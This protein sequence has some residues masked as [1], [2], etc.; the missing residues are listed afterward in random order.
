M[1]EGHADQTGWALVQKGG[2]SAVVEGARMDVRV[3]TADVALQADDLLASVAAT[4]MSHISVVRKS[5]FNRLVEGA[6]VTFDIVR[7]GARKSTGAMRLEASHAIPT[8]SCK[9]GSICPGVLGD[10]Q[11][12]P[13]VWVHPDDDR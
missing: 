11:D 7:I 9:I 1:V 4:S 6:K 8:T 3:L 12:A 5:G 2:F 13:Y 10:Q